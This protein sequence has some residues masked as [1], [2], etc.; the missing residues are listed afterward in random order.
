[1]D[2]KR[3]RLLLVLCLVIAFIAII[4][5][6]SHQKKTSYFA[7]KSVHDDVTDVVQQWA[8]LPTLPDDD[9]ILEVIWSKSGA[10]FEFFPYAAQ[11]LSNK[12]NIKF[13]NSK[14]P[15]ITYMDINAVANSGGKVK[16]VGDLATAVMQNYIPKE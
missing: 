13:K 11:D 14:T 5:L 3:V 9:S 15:V 10:H 2:K 4:V 12:I 1:M 8:Q 7:V 16:S 6:S